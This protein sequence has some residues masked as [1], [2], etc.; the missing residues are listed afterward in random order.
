M[1]SRSDWPGSVATTF[2]GRLAAVVTCAV[3]LSGPAAA[4]TSGPPLTHSQSAAAAT[5]SKGWTSSNW[6][7]YAITS[8][9]YTRATSTWRV[10]TVVAS[11]TPTYSS[12]WVGIDG[13]DNTSL[14]QVGTEQDYSGGSAHYSAWWEIL[15]AAGTSIAS[16]T[17]HPGD[18]MVA[19]IAR[20]S[21]GGTWTISLADRTTGRS[22]SI[23]RAYAGPGDSAEWI[24]EAPRVGTKIATLAH[25]STTTFVGTANGRSLQ[26][27][28]AN[29]GTMIQDGVA[30]STPSAQDSRTRAFSVRYT[31]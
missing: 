13:F 7:G 20:N 26:L 12:S 23:V 3:L 1:G 19:T 10:P 28:A 11:A 25:T 27:S 18:T 22:F 16:L 14:I 21:T 5:V 6:S 2:L 9:P 31:N 4:A 15:P 30:V 8:G 17:V 29:R 24:H